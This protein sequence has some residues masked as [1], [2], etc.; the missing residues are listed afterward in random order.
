MQPSFHKCEIR[1]SH[2]PSTCFLLPKIADIP[3]HQQKKHKMKKLRKII[4]D[5]VRQEQEYAMKT[6]QQWPQM[7]PVRVSSHKKMIITEDGVGRR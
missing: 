4:R 7:Q 2:L 5:I 1:M 3:L 6:N